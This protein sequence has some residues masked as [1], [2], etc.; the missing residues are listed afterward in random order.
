MTQ[1]RHREFFHVEMHDL[2]LFLP[3]PIPYTTVK[4]RSDL[5]LNICFQSLSLLHF[6]RAGPRWRHV[7]RRGCVGGSSLRSRRSVCPVRAVLVRFAPVRSDSRRCIDFVCNL[8]T[9]TN[10]VWT[11]LQNS[12]GMHCMIILCQSFFVGGFSLIQ[13]NRIFF[14]SS[15]R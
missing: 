10:Q 1:K 11:Y 13:D 3:G 15:I 4:V 8:A 2:H 14:P 7:L 6:G 5:I 12:N 9:L